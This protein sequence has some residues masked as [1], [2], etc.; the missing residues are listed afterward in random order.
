[1]EGFRM[2]HFFVPIGGETGLVTAGLRE[3]VLESETSRRRT[4]GFSKLAAALRA[5]KA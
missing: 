3:K 4:T 2:T 5:P 1:M